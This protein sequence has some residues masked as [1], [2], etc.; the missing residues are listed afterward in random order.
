[1]KKRK[2]PESERSRDVAAAVGQYN[3]VNGVPSRCVTGVS[4]RDV[5]SPVI[6]A[7]NDSNEQS[8]SMADCTAGHY[9]SVTTLL[10][11][12]ASNQ[13]RS[14][15][16][17]QLDQRVPHCYQTRPTIPNLRFNCNLIAN[18]GAQFAV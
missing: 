7:S 4:P 16:R 3:R 13:Q 2:R 1:M 6:D 12:E 17:Q 14:T 5:P 8:V 15:S 9:C 10:G 18:I 11:K